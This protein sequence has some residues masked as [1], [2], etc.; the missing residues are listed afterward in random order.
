M[1]DGAG[2]ART[3]DGGEA[4][5]WEELVLPGRCRRAETRGLSGL[6]EELVIRTVR[7]E[8]GG[9]WGCRTAGALEGRTGASE[10][11]LSEV[12]PE[13]AGGRE[14]GARASSDG[15]RSPLASRA[16]VRSPWGR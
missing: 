8:K 11:G 15:A 5:S 3:E 4:S 13:R 1:S 9:A 7:W 10:A 16:R 12:F 6:S 14:A 2:F